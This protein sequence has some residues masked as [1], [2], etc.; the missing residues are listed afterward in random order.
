[1]IC[2]S[3]FQ[4]DLRKLR[5]VSKKKLNTLGTLNVQNVMVLDQQM[6]HPRAC[7]R[8]VVV[9]VKLPLIKDL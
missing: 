4:S 7:A 2:Q 3:P 5:I 8:L 9:L 1:M 6:A